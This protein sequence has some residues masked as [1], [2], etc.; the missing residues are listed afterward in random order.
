MALAKL[1]S[2]VHRLGLFDG[3]GQFGPENESCTLQTS[4][5]NSC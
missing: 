5:T 1:V 2:A 4:V 3:L